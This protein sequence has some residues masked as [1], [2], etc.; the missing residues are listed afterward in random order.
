MIRL[1]RD[2]RSLFHLHYHLHHEDQI[3]S[4]N[5]ATFQLKEVDKVHSYDL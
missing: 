3:E 2:H 5:K 4:L 1:H